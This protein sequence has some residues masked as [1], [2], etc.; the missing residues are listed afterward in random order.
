M[1]EKPNS[2]ICYEPFSFYGFM[3]QTGMV[4]GYTVGD[5]RTLFV[6]NGK[7]KTNNGIPYFN[8]YILRSDSFERPEWAKIRITESN[9]PVIYKLIRK[10]VR[11]R[12]EKGIHLE[13]KNS[14]QLE[15][16]RWNQ[17]EY[18]H[19]FPRSA[20][21]KQAHCTVLSKGDEYALKRKNWREKNT[22]T[23]T[24]NTVMYN[25]S[26]GHVTII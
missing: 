14:S 25:S 7:M 11:R 9:N 21:Y 20:P 6:S 24:V 23:Q 22:V 5:N 3:V 12:D 4:Y 13:Y 10:A 18:K 2:N 16:L 8:A 26:N 19:H 17:D 1:K 15:E